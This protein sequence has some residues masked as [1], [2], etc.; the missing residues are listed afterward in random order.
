MRNSEIF[1]ARL[2]E[3]MK[4]R[5]MKNIELANKSGIYKGSIANY[6]RGQWT[7][8]IDKI[9]QLA[10]ALEVSPRWLMGADVPMEEVLPRLVREQNESR[11]IAAFYAADEKTKR[12]VLQLLDLEGLKL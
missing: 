12:I 7:P 3:A 10:G 1:A 6:L 11:L 4:T 8:K 2:R 5:G 9:E